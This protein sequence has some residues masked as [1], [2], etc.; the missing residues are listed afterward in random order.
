MKY[1]FLRDLEHFYG[2]RKH[3]TRIEGGIL[4]QSYMLKLKDEKEEKL[5]LENRS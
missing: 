1:H 3:K 2:T 5:L 4:S